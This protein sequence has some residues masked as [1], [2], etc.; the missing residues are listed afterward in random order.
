MVGFRDFWGSS[1]NADHW[2]KAW[3]AAFNAARARF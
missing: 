2:R 1:L 3:D